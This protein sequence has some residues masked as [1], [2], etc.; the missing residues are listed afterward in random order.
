MKVEELNIVQKAE[1]IRSM[2]IE[3][4]KEKNELSMYKAYLIANSNL[5]ELEYI[6]YEKYK[7]EI[8]LEF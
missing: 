5:N 6:D 1:I 7:K 4:K 3:L 2:A 8:N